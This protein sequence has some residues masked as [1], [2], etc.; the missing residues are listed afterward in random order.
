[1]KI[2]ACQDLDAKEMLW[3]HHATR[4]LLAVWGK[5]FS[6]F[7]QQQRLSHLRVRNLP[8]FSLP[9]GGQRDLPEKKLLALQ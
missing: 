6:I 8:L 3:I 1:M 9:T 5:I 4:L 7:L 2:D